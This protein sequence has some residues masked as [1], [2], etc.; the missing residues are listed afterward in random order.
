MSDIIEILGE[1]KFSGSRS[2]DLK[3]SIVLE[4]TNQTRYDNNLFYTLSQQTQFI[5]EKNN[6][7][8][9]H[10]FALVCK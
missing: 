3:S 10:F 2:S 5:S 6:C 9:S 7:N 8:N 1:K 4:E